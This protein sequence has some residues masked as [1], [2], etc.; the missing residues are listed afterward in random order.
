[1]KTLIHI[2]DLHFG[3]ITPDIVEQLETQIGIARPDLC[4]ISGDLTMRSRPRE[5]RQARAFIDRLPV[6]HMVIPGNHDLPYVNL[7]ERFTDPYRRFRKFISESLNPRYHD[8]EIAIMGVNTARSWVPHWTWKEGDFS[9]DQLEMVKDFFN[10]VGAG[11]VKIVFTHHPFLP[12]P[13]R[14]R[15]Y[16]VRHAR[17]ALSVFAELEIDLLLGGHLHLSYSGD[18]SAFHTLIKRSMLCVQASTATSSR[19][20]SGVPNGFNFIAIEPD[21]VDVHSWEWSGKAFKR[22]KTDGFDRIEA[23]WSARQ[24]ETPVQTK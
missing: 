6:P 10:R 12:P 9:I 21:H 18:I 24:P 14:P 17:R 19:L 11:R 7:L 22:I 16:L 23:G 4:I 2:T 15:T 3:R 5:W 1:M 13:Q 20:R 8:H